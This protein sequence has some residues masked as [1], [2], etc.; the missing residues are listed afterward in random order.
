[1]DTV[2]D[3]EYALI[4]QRYGLIGVFVFLSFIIYLARCSIRV[5]GRYYGAA[6]FML[7]I[8]SLFF[9]LTN[10]MFSGYQL[11]S[12]VVIL[13]LLCIVSYRDHVYE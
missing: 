5:I 8:F 7:V 6:L 3:S 12:L 11:M 13:L 4:I 1:M 9:M 2:I 10:N